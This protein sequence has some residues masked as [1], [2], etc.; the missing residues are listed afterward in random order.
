[1]KTFEQ[2]VQETRAAVLKAMADKTPI[3]LTRGKSGKPSKVE[4]H[5]RRLRYV[6]SDETP[7][8]YGDIV[9]VK[10]WTLDNFK[11]SP[12][13]IW[14]HDYERPPIGTVPDVRK[15][16]D[17]LAL[18]A[19]A[20]YFERDVNE[21]A[22]TIF[23]MAE[24]GG[25]RGVSVGFMPLESND[26]QDPEEREKMGLGKFGFEFTKA[27][28]LELSQVSVPANPNAVALSY[29]PEEFAKELGTALTPEA[30]ALFG[31]DEARIFVRDAGDWFARAATPVLR[32]LSLI[33]GAPVISLPSTTT[34][35]AGTLTIKDSTGD[36]AITIDP[37]PVDVGAQIAAA[38][39][40]TCEQVTKS[41]AESLTSDAFRKSIQGAV[42]SVI[43]ASVAAS[44]V[45]APEPK[46]SDD[47][48]VKAIL[49]AGIRERLS[50]IEAGVRKNRRS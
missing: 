34:T 43:T 25:I 8:R 44:T 38:V 11:K 49:D 42:E 36:Y 20:E 2:H 31:K 40:A 3:R 26:P 18:I 33:P 10:G 35:T 41:I 24:I 45:R 16:K 4:G 22:D 7:D 32:D 6:A 17:P 21:F 13:L 23:R 27:D 29:T 14:G 5:A 12:V 39:K 9:R 48:A 46:P 28:L 30:R 15:S 1:M 47:S 37:N 19:E 50:R